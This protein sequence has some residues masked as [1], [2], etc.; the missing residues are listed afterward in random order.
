MKFWASAYRFGTVGPY[1]TRE[2]AEKAF[3]DTFIAATSCVVGYGAIGPH[4]DMRF[5]RMAREEVD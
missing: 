5:A 1:G 4:F 2:E 3:F